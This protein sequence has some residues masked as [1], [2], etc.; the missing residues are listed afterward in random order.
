MS[1]LSHNATLDTTDYIAGINRMKKETS[2]FTKT[3]VDNFDDLDAKLRTIGAGIATYFSVTAL[4]NF[5]SEV[6]RV[7]GEFQQLEIGLETMLGNKAKADALMRQVIEFAAKTP[8]DLQQVASGTKQLIAYGVA[9]ED[10][11]PT[12]RRL[13]DIASG[14]GLAFG[15]MAY[16]YGTTRVQGRLYAQ[17]LR[18]FTG[19]GIPLI[20]QLAKQFNVATGEVNKLVSEGKVGF[21]E[22]EK[23]IKAMTDEGGR[24]YNLTEKNSKTLTGMISNL[25]DSFQQMYNDIGKQTQGALV[26]GIE[27][28]SSLVEHWREI[29]KVLAVIITAYGTYKAAVLAVAAAQKIM[30]AVDAAKAF[31][32]LAKSVHSAKDAMLLFNMAC[33]ANPWILLASAVTT[34]IVAFNMFGSSAEE[35]QEEV[36]GLN[37][38]NKEAD[39]EFAKQASAIDALK[40]SIESNTTSLE[41]K[42]KAIEQLKK[43]IPGYNAELDAEGRLIS[44]NTEK[45]KEYLVQ[46]EKQ[47]RLKAAQE[48]L[49]DLYRKKRLEEK[50]QKKNQ[51]IIDQQGPELQRQLKAAQDEAAA[52][53]QAAF[54]SGDAAVSAM[55]A[56]WNNVDEALLRTVNNAEHA[57]GEATAALATINTDIEDVRNEIE[58]TSAE[59]A[60]A[61]KQAQN[62]GGT[63]NEQLKRARGEVTR[64]KNELSDLRS[65]KIPATDYAQAIADKT[66]ELKEAQGKLNTLLHGSSTGGSGGSSA[67]NDARRRAEEEAEWGEEIIQQRKRM[68]QAITQAS[69]DSMQ[70]GYAKTRAEQLFEH[71][72]NLEAI[73]ARADE[74]RKAVYEHNKNLWEQ[75]HKDAVYETSEEGRGGW[76]AVQLTEAQQG[77]LDALI[78]SETYKWARIQQ[79]QLET[80]LSGMYDY[81]KEYGSIQEQKYAI[82]A[83]YDRK[84]AQEN[85]FWRKRALENEKQKTL[86]A[87]NSEDLVKQ[88]NLEM[89]FTEYGKILAT[90][91]EETLEALEKYTKSDAFKARSIEDQRSIY[92]SMESARKQLGTIGGVSMSDIGKNLYEYNNALIEYNQASKEMLELTRLA[93]EAEEAERLATQA[94]TDAKD[95]E[96]RAVALANQQLALQRKNEAQGNYAAGQRRQRDAQARLAQTQQEATRSLQEFQNSIEQV[97]NIAKG[98]ASGSMK[99]L[100]EALGRKTQQRIGQFIAGS[101]SYDKAIKTMQDTLAK[102]GQGM[103]F[104]VSKIQNLAKEILDSGD[105]ID[106]ANIGGK[107]SNLLEEMFGSD[108]KDVSKFGKDLTQVLSKV[109]HQADEEGA[110]TMGTIKKVGEEAVKAI[111]KT[112]G[113]LWVM[114]VG[115]ILDLLDVLSEGIG[116]LVEALLNSVGNA[117]EGIL[118]EIGNGKFFERIATGVGNVVGGVIKGV[119]NLISGGT[120]FG[121]GNESE[122]EEKI[123]AWLATNEAL[124]TSIKSLTETMKSVD[125]TN[126]ESIEAYQKALDAEKEWEQNQRNAIDARASEWTN[127]G[128]GF[129]GLG[130]KGSFNA[131]MPGGGSWVWQEFNRA[132]AEH[133][134]NK[135]VSG[136]DIWNL[137]PEEM[138]VLRD[139]APS[140]WASLF[141]GDGHRN[142]QDLVNQYIE[143]AGTL[144][145]LT[146]ALNEKLT[147]YSWDS[148]KSSYID[149]LK[150]LTASTEDFAKNMEELISNALITAFVNSEEIQSRIRSLY[151]KIAKYAGLDSEGGTELTEAEINDLRATN[152]KLAEDMLAWRDAAVAAGLIKTTAEEYN[153]SASTGGFQAMSQ[154]TGEELNGR[155]TAI[156]MNTAQIYASVVETVN[157]LIIQNDHLANIEKYT[158][159]LSEINEKLE[160]IKDNT[161]EL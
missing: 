128:Y 38:V 104:F 114:I 141:N 131:H 98:V 96:A 37:K 158:K 139:F 14:L 46:L 42:K 89:L 145:S 160:S 133:G 121:G 3:A 62:T 30:I 112:G 122:M 108:N 29:A 107:I 125:S 115:L 149:M 150:D 103:D 85:D 52:G 154:D 59:I 35:A 86:E 106:E 159:L 53:Q 63:F 70:E 36:Q 76:Q 119:G 123:D 80:E 43:I 84:I 111:S 120:F 21:P 71:N 116:S 65:G 5:T 90:P 87:L 135:T 55:T 138:K 151:E 41:T 130:G 26:T 57:V 11:I 110:D 142:P 2:S 20:E 79:E 51:E 10:V 95:D 109:F 156:Q 7:R 100:W 17:D 66:K 6:I 4:K 93:A 118:T 155:F 33:K 77:E 105:S 19:R 83:I 157:L 60:A 15:D 18:Q 75:A 144:D 27:A 97:G 99:Q 69:I 92:Q 54:N 113:S 161:D 102:S 72:K 82:A 50:K 73:R 137:S 134:Y 94:L 40:S 140:A 56:R 81:L 25:G 31:L 91:L 44:S 64:L 74:M 48:E 101:R 146:S 132:L 12:M 23:A 152:E 49:E 45:I 127:S 117:I 143:R 88:L 9:A 58:G 22:V 136:S 28:V 67:V 147:G 39:E 34:A 47:I 61:G 1:N 68:E 153:Q 129:L 148:F 13:G 126:K 78:E 8:F 32:S 24:F 16:L 124:D